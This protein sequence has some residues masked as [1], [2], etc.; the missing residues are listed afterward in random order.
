MVTSTQD[1]SPMED[2][3]MAEVLDQEVKTLVEATLATV[4]VTISATA[5]VIILVIILV[6]TSVII[7]GTTIM[8]LSLVSHQSSTPIYDLS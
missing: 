6:T 3:A 8:D 4:L 7:L 5:S 2:G 1:S